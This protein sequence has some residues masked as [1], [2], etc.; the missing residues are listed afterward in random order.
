[1]RKK[2]L[3]GLISLSLLLVPGCRKAGRIDS[4]S[5]MRSAE[6]ISSETIHYLDDQAIA[7]ADSSGDKASLRSEALRAYNLVNEQR[8]RAGLEPLVWDSGLENTSDVRARECE[9]SFSHT[10][11]DGSAWYTVNSQI[12]GGENLAYG[13]NNAA[14]V[15]DGWMHSPTHR[16]NILYPTFTKI[17][18]SV[19][20]ADDGTYYW[21]QEF[22]Y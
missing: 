6:A 13:Y 5:A 10:R 20:V 16:D 7:L 3:I 11:P 17:S 14:D 9:T 19:Y 4:D 1:M 18:I 8:T 15:L 2:I 22:G 12:M 21:S